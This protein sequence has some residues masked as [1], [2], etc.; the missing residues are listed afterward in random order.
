[1]EQLEHAANA[2]AFHLL[3][4]CFMPDHV[5]ILVQ[6]K[7]DEARLLQFVQRFKQLTGYRYKRAYGYSLWQQS[8]YDRVLRDDEDIVT[9]G[10]YIFGNPVT[11]GLVADT[12][13]YALSGG[14]YF[15]G[16]R[17]DGAEAASL[18]V[19]TEN[20]GADA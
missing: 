12:S 4:Y 14:L 15:T 13:D 9:V 8:F 3:A 2:L 10:E 5:H 1:M 11:A 19:R 7:N 6:G 20:A 17:K 18:R 16:R